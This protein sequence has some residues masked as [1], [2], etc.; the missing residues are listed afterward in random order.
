MCIWCILR[1]LNCS[2]WCTPDSR[3]L[4]SDFCQH[5][6][7]HY[8]YLDII[9]DDVHTVQNLVGNILNPKLL[10][11]VDFIFTDSISSGEQTNATCTVA[12]CQYKTRLLMY[13]IQY[14]RFVHHVVCM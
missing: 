10:S 12:N 7:S 9:S 1:Q 6:L 3:A 13:V 5:K 8:Y 4:C 2:G 14:S 11:Y